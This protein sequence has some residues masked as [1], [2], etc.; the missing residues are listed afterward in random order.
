MRGL[1]VTRQLEAPQRKLTPIEETQ[2]EAHFF[3]FKN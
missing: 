1:L 3:I 2:V